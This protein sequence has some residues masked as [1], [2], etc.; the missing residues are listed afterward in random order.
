[1]WGEDT[2]LISATRAQAIG[3]GAL[4]PAQEAFLRN[5]GIRYPVAYT[6]QVFE[7]CIAWT[8]SDPAV[9]D[10]R[11]REWD[12]L[13]QLRSAMRGSATNHI[14]FTVLRVPR[15]G[16]NV[17]PEPVELHAVCGPGD[18]GEPVVTVLWDEYE[19]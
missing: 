3:D 5:L 11:G 18:E 7:D 15:G 13:I 14:R 10:E 16:D 1:M 6:R 4:I 9:Q 17:D 12:V 19:R 8:A 2:T